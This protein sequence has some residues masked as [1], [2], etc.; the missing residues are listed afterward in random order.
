MIPFVV[1]V[2]AVVDVAI[3]DVAVDAA[4]DAAVVV[5]DGAGVPFFVRTHLHLTRRLSSSNKW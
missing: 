5:V 1:V 4:V 2:V 3:V